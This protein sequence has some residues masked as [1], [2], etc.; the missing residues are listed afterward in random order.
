MLN[1]HIEKISSL[2]RRINA[3]SPHPAAV[4][5]Y[6]DKLE[7]GKVTLGLPWREE[8]IGNPVTGAIHT[9]VVT[10][11]ID[12]TLGISTLCSEKISPSLNPML[13]IRVDHLG[14]SA[15]KSDIKATA[16]ICKTSSRVIFVEGIVWCKTPNKPI[17]KATGCTVVL[18]ELDLATW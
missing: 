1:K 8:F 3:Y 6:F 11:L 12:H 10:C 18:Q 13:D 17:A 15:I 16:W 5:I 4:G 7:A 9:G 14:E 2:I